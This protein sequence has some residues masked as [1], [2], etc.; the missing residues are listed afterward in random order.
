MSLQGLRPEDFAD[1]K[2]LYR[3][4]QEPRGFDILPSIPG[5][6][7]E[8]AWARRVEAVIDSATGLTAHFVSAEDLIAAKL[9]AGPPQDLADA[10]AVQ[11]ALK[12]RDSIKN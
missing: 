8:A 2:S 11:K 4:G 5:L 12:E 9:A 6:E 3:F 7:F 1:R 10:D